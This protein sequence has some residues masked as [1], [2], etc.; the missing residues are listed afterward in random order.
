MWPKHTATRPESYLDLRAL[1]MPLTT[2]PT[3]YDSI[4]V[5][6]DSLD[7]LIRLLKEDGLPME[8]FERLRDELGI[9]AARLARAIRIADRTLRR[10]RKA[11]RL[12]PD[13][14][15]RLLRVARLFERGVEVLGSKDRARAWFG[16][17]IPALSGATPLAYADTEP[18][19]REVE[20]VLGR[21]AHGVFS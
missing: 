1:I 18:G 14:S 2:N 6:A 3:S 4:H 21:I 5:Q 12:Q 8:S 11:G 9:S 17:P 16:E 13:E 20:R 19:A 7:D 10:R 15:E